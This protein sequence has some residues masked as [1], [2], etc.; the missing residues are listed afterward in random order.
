MLTIINLILR[1]SCGQLPCGI[2]DDTNN[3]YHEPKAARSRPG[4][5]KPSPKML[6]GEE[7]RCHSLE[8]NVVTNERE[9]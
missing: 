6:R 3:P 8:V 2:E 1:K 5:L 7:L 9:A 4:Y